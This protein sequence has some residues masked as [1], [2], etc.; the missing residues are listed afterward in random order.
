MRPAE[1]ALQLLESEQF[2]EFSRRGVVFSLFWLAKN[3]QVVG[4]SI[5][6]CKN[7]SRLKT[8]RSADS[9]GAPQIMDLI[10]KAIHLSVSLDHFGSTCRK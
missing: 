4:A 2:T 7:L 3:A 1:F 6:Q 10:Q 9:L 8:H 5:P